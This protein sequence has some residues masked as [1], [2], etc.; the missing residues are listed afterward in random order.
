MHNAYS[1]EAAQEREKLTRLI[2]LVNNHSLVV[3]HDYV[4][5]AIGTFKESRA[6]TYSSRNYRIH[7]IDK[8]RAVKDT[9]EIIVHNFSWVRNQKAVYSVVPVFYHFSVIL[10]HF[11]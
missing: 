4:L 8:R 1:E 2:A 6:L 5:L 7:S 11:I 10:F 3:Y 9:E